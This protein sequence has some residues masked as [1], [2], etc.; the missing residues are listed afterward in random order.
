MD[1]ALT[2]L[3]ERVDVPAPLEVVF[4]AAMD[5]ERQGEWILGTTVRVR[6]GDGRSVGSEIE[7]VTG[8]R[9]IG[10]TDTMRITRW[11]PPVRCEVVHTG[12]L[13]RGIGIFAVHPRG[14]QEATFEWT[15]QLDLPLG[16]VGKLGW[17]L[18]RPGFAWGLRQS[19]DRFVDFCRD[20]P[21]GHA[22]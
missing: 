17:N 7:A 2:E 6:Q 4:A 3:A 9:G 14:T 10:V 22:R 12:R 8:V 16:A 15:E 19:L 5:W 21:D 13:V 11:E 1:P 18:I 20:Y